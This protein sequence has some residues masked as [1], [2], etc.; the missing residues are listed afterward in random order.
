[1]TIA[2]R[3]KL[4]KSTSLRLGDV[5]SSWLP[6]VPEASDHG[7]TLTCRAHNPNIPGHAATTSTVLQITFAPRVTLKLGYNLDTRPVTEGE[8]VFFE[9]EVASNPPPLTVTWYKDGEEVKHDMRAGVLVSGN[10]LV[11]QMVRRVSAGNYTCAATNTLTTTASNSVVLDIKYLPVCVDGPQS[12]VV[13]EGEDVRLTCR[14]DAK[15]EDDLRFTWYFNNTL[16]TVE[17]ERHRVQVRPGL[18]YLDYTPRSSRDYGSLACWATN[19]VGTQADPC[20]F[21]V[22]EAGQHLTLSHVGPP[23]RVESC[24]LVNLTGGTLEVKCSPGHDGGL[25]QWFIGRVYDA[26]SHKLLATMEETTPRFQMS[27]LTPGHDYVIT[28]T[29]VNSK[30]ASE[31]QEIDAIRLKV[32]EKR[33][34][35]VSSPGVSPLVGVFL[36]LVGGFVGLLLLAISFTLIRSYRC[37]CLVAGSDGTRE[38][39]GD[40]ASSHAPA[41]KASPTSHP[42]DTRPGPDVLLS[43]SSRALPLPSHGTTPRA[44]LVTSYCGVDARGSGGEVVTSGEGGDE[45]QLSWSRRMSSSV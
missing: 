2:G 23:E 28:I 31:P 19:T 44:R 24:D 4:L 25:P 9:C 35:E 37:R 7:A 39:D 1:M 10:N 3:S 33:M 20:Q 41:A 27:G 11:L 6:L 18:S 22:L 36:G 29:A 5:T 30:G 16:D 17:V 14:V 8:D 32:A 12:V 21:T 15:P 26:I 45:G 42:L 40:G 13:A 43:A 34:G 38:N